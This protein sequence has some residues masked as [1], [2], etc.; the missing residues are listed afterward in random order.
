MISLP[1]HSRVWSSPGTPN[2]SSVIHRI[3]GTPRMMSVYSVANS[4]S[5]NSAGVRVLRAIATSSPTATMHG[6]QTRKILTSSQNALAIVP[7]VCRKTDQS[8]NERRTFCHPDVLGSSETSKSDHDRRRRGRDRRAAHPLAPLVLLA[9]GARR[10]SRG[11][12]GPSPRASL[13]VDD[14]NF[15]G[16]FH[17][18]RG[19]LVE[20]TRLAQVEQGVVGALDERV[21]LL[22]E[23]APR[24]ALG[25]CR[26]AGTARP[27]LRSPSR[28]R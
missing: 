24:L 3:T 1:N 25:R 12:R 23:Q 26:P 17:P 4:R 28:R 6:A 5:G 15:G 18:L 7:N 19:D 16:L 2:P 11:G 20:L 21:V 22:E 13:E 27:R 8:K 9:T 14:R 10:R